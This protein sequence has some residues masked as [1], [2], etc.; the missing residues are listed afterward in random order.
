MFA[1]VLSIKLSENVS[2]IVEFYVFQGFKYKLEFGF[3][4]QLLFAFSGWSVLLKH[5]RDLINFALVRTFNKMKLFMLI[6]K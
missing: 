6:I 5:M 1:I 4:I 2:S 3:N